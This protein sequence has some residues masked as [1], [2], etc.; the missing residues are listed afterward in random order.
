M[1][2]NRNG[3]PW[4]ETVDPQ[5]CNLG[6]SGAWKAMSRDPQRTPFQWDASRWAGFS[7]GSTKP[8]LPVHPNYKQINLKWQMENA[9]RSTHHFYKYIALLRQLPSFASGDY[10]SKVLGDN[11]L[12]YSRYVL[13]AFQYNMCHVHMLIII[14]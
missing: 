13:L 8:W 9:T 10:H 11:V 3:I 5:A 4:K 12:A 2:D 1:L 14:H 6:E 7:Q